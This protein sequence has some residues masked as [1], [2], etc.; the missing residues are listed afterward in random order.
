MLKDVVVEAILTAQRYVVSQAKDIGPVEQK[1][2]KD[3]VTRVDKEAEKI[4]I[5]TIRKY[6]PHAAFYGE[7]TGRCGE[8]ELTIVVD[9]IDATTNYIKKIPFYD[10]MVSAY[11][12]NE[13]ILGVISC[14]PTRDLYVAER[15]KGA[16]LNGEPIHVSNTDTLER[17]VIGWNRSNHTQ[18]IIPRSQKILSAVM[19][20]SC[21]FRVFGTGGLDHCYLAQGSLDAVISPLAEPFHS[22]GYLI[23]EEAG[24][25]V[26]D[27]EGRPHSL[28][29]ET[30]VAANPALHPLVLRLIEET[31]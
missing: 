2:S 8:S 28:E 9:P 20:Q 3:F 7:E 23:M 22:A 18:A 6:H 1:S 25:K 4:I 27:Y 16:T 26:T 5:E 29:S 30:I 15:G 21:T 11:R 14:P 10:I 17:A 13:L 31:R 19:A 24:A 12:G